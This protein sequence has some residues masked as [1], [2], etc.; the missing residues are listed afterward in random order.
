MSS[1]RF[2]LSTPPSGGRA[3]LQGS[4]AHHLR[5]VLRAEPGRVVELIDGTGQI[6]RA[7]V[8]CHSAGGVEFSEV[9]LLAASS[10]SARLGLIQ[11]LCKADKLEWI[12]EKCTELGIDE[13]YLLEA[14]RSVVKIPKERLA[15]KMERWQK[16]ILA[17]VKQSRR[18]TLPVLHP[19][20]PLP[21]LCRALPDG[22]KLMLSES[23]REA[24]LKSVVRSSPWQSAVFCIGPE[25]GWTVQEHETLMQSGFQAASLGS[26]I[27]RTETAAIVAAAILQYEREES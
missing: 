26:G 2:L 1:R 11:S 15:G 16:I 17:A 9:E 6:W 13:I 18:R 10:P 3:T 8:D 14:A 5:H 20:S 7:V 21:L 19:P 12:L 25:G 4:E 27:L 22:L 24:S 23:E